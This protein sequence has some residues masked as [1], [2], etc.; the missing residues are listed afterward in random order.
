MPAPL[1]VP[2]PHAGLSPAL[3]RATLS[4]PITLLRTA[5]DP[6]PRHTY[7]SVCHRALAGPPILPAPPC[8]SLSRRA[9]AP[10]RQ[11]R[12]SAMSATELDAPSG[13]S[14]VT[15][16]ITAP[17]P[18]AR[19]VLRRWTAAYGLYTLATNL[20]FTHAV[21]VLYLAANGY[22][23]FAIGLFETAFHAAKFLAEIP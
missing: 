8:C 22:S 19:R 13:P 15:A 14:A 6:G 2:A 3:A 9:P 17:A 10:P 23:P 18:P 5:A 1:A 4:S 16:S 11:M 20:I 7:S 12:A 21:W